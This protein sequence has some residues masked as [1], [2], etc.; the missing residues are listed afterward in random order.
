MLQF[1]R[2]GQRKERPFVRKPDTDA[3]AG[4]SEEQKKAALH[5]LQS[6][7]TVTGVVGKAGTG[8]TTMMRATVEALQGE[9]GRRVFVFAPSTQARDVLRKEGFQDAATLAMLLKN[10]RLQQIAKGQPIWVDE[11]GLISSRDMRQLTEVAKRNGNRLILSGDYSQHSSVEAGDAFRLLE[12]EAGVKLARLTQI[13]RQTMPGYRKAVEAISKGT[14]KSVQ[15]GFDAL[16]KMGWIAES[17]GDERHGHL[18]KDYL[19]AAE[20]GKSALIIAPTHAEGD[21]LTAELR[22]TLKSEELSAKNALYSA[23]LHQLDGC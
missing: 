15:K 7:D 22:G 17:T 19:R 13:R 23:S 10:E 16:D 8:K 20:D 9:Q 11:A 6:R 3:L 14:G 4:L 2:D 12:Q 5:V 1:A 21:R 18:I